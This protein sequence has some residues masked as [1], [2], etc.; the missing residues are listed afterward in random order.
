MAYSVIFR[1][2]RTTG[3]PL[4]VCTD[5]PNLPKCRFLYH[6]PA[7][8]GEDTTGS[9]SLF[10]ESPWNTGLL[11]EYRELELKFDFFFSKFSACTG[12]RR[13]S[14]S[15]HPNAYTTVVGGSFRM[16]RGLPCGNNLRFRAW[17]R[18]KAPCVPELEE[19]LPQWDANGRTWEYSSLS[20][21]RLREKILTKEV[22]IDSK[23]LAMLGDE[24]I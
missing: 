5:S 1:T 19:K 23:G 2:E 11:L 16:G 4:G 10:W 8:I 7:A 13:I 24:K 9:I 18:F 20:K 14:Y 3:L 15:C 12:L 22:L 6:C 21:T 17:K